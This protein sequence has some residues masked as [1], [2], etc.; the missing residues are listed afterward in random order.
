MVGRP[1][2]GVDEEKL[3]K[4]GEL[5]FGPPAIDARKGFGPPV[6]C[7]LRPTP[8]DELLLKAPVGWDFIPN[9]S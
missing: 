2:T 8:R 7:G 5:P 6:I 9:P 1:G 3:P 4:L